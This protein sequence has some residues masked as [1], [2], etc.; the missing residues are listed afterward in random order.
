MI[1][2]SSFYPFAS[3]L[4]VTQE[5]YDEKALVKMK[6]LTYEREFEFEYKDVGEISDRFFI[7]SSQN[8]FGFWLLFSIMLEFSLL[9]SVFY[10]FAA[11]HLVLLRIG[12]IL[13]VCGLILY[14][15]SFKKSWHIYISDRNDNILTYMKLT[16]H[17][18]DRITQVINAI[19]NK[20]ENVQEFSAASPFPEEKAAFEH[21]Y[22]N[23]SEMETTIDRFYENEIIGFEKSIF[24]ERI[25]DIQYSRLSGKIYRGKLG[26]DI[27]GT[28][29]N[30][31]TLLVSIII[32]FFLGFGITLGIPISM[33]LA[34]AVLGLYA[35]VL[36]SLPI[37]FIK[38]EVIGLYDK[39]GNILY[40][41]YLNR[42]NKD[43]VEEII[44]FIQSRI[45]PVTN[46][47]LLKEQA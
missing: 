26:N 6:S 31:V 15:T 29:L 14:I 20:S 46:D 16:P 1:K 9:V 34:Y 43:K 41:T 19:K 13:Y 35:L 39:N 12:Q 25:Y 18:Q 47:R 3:L 4:K 17:N 30:V 24:S 33:N 23:P 22:Y 10:N 45:P 28:V 27:W 44:K 8:N 32:G 2:I 42:A 7:N 37:K 38:R 5:F 36:I 21:T 40:W 11:T